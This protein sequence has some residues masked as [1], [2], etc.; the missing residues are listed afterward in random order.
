MKLIPPSV[1]STLQAINRANMPET[2]VIQTGTE[3]GDGSGGTAIVWSD[4]TTT[5]CRISPMTR[6]QAERVTAFGTEAIEAFALAFPTGTEIDE[7]QRVVVGDRIFH[8]AGVM[9]PHSYGSEVTVIGF[10]RGN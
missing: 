3:T 1:L 2:A 9:G 7:G 10:E 6:G 4:T 8:V 5:V